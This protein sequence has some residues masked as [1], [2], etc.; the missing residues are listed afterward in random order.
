[1]TT[2]VRLMDLPSPLIE[3]GLQD[4]TICLK[5]PDWIVKSPDGA[6]GSHYWP[7]YDTTPEQMVKVLE[8]MERSVAIVRD[9]HELLRRLLELRKN[10]MRVPQVAPGT[11]DPEQYRAF[12]E[13]C[14]E[15]IDKLSPIMGGPSGGT[16]TFR[17]N[18]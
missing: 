9:Q 3:F 8:K 18:D 7:W 12:D 6:H 15:L 13:E 1:M 5:F 17:R 11:P 16:T 4:G 2:E 10:Q 14:E